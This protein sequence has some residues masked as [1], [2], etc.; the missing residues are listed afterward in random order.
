MTLRSNFPRGGTL[1]ALRK[2]QWTALGIPEED[3]EKPK[4]AVVNTSSELSICF[5]HLD[6]VAEVVKEGIREAGG[7][8]FEVRTTGP[9]ATSSTVRGRQG[10]TSSRPA[11]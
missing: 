7:L 8:P 2:A 9:P 1:W 3:F 10:A 4:V 11:I 5:S 6:E